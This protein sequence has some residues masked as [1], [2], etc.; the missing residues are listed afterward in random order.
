MVSGIAAEHPDPDDI[1]A[2]IIDTARKHGHNA[3]EVLHQLMAGTPG[4]P[5][6]G[7]SPRNNAFK[8]APPSQTVHPGECLRFEH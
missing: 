7:R 2:Q 5:Q 8:S 3:Y 6:P 4:S 1:T